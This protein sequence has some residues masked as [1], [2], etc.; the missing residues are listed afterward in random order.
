MRRFRWF[1]ALAAVG[2]VSAA[3]W[4]V[5]AIL[6]RC[7]VRSTYL[8]VTCPTLGDFPED[9]FDVEM[10]ASAVNLRGVRIATYNIMNQ[11]RYQMTFIECTMALDVFLAWADHHNWDVSTTFWNGVDVQLPPDINGQSPSSMRVRNCIASFSGHRGDTRSMRVVYDKDNN[12]MYYTA[13][14]HP[15][16]MEN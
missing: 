6:T 9:S 16:L 5:W 7:E 4:M 10:P 14:I 13:M 15:P 12:R 11:I 3:T 1:I 2:V 8:S